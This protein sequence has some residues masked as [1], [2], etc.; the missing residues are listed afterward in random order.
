[1]IFSLTKKMK[2]FTKIFFFSLLLIYSCSTKL[3]NL[4][5]AKEEIAAYYESGKY[6]MEV[7]GVISD[8]IKEFESVKVEDSTAV[9]FDVDETALSNYETTKETD[10]GYVPE[11][12]NRWIEEARAPAIKGVKNLYE[13]LAGK[14]IKI[15]FITGRK[16]F[17]YT[18][19][20]NNLHSAG[21]ASFDTLIVRMHGEY[22]LGAVEFK[23]KKREELT[24]RGYKIAGT[25]GDQWSDLK[26]GYHGIQIKIP[27]YLY[28]IK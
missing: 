10:F 25:V 3:T 18:P 20:L 11:I 24:A 5:F 7:A 23:S 9:I 12:W 27:N 28:Y 19:T 4:D 1:M 14:G 15:I 26:G 21:Y 8:A 17:Q 16:D 22:N 2:S 13:F 6:D